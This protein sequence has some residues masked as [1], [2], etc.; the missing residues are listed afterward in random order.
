MHAIHGQKVIKAKHH[1]V[2]DTSHAAP[3][4][5]AHLSH[6][7]MQAM[8]TNTL[9]NCNLMGEPPPHTSCAVPFTPSS[10]NCSMMRLMLQSAEMSALVNSVSALL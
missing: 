8:A 4:M 3:C 6:M 10:F 2:V 7:S 5:H 9:S 1:L